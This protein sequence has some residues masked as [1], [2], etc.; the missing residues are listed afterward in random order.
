MSKPRKT[1]PVETLKAKVNYALATTATEDVQGRHALC[2][3]LESAL[4]STGNYHGYTYLSKF[5]GVTG[6][7]PNADETR[8]MYL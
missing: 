2:W 8:R 3:L 1:I 4:H 6:F 7:D 5:H